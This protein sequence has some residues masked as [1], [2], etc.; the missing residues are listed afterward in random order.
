MCEF[1]FVNTGAN[2]FSPA[3]YMRV[4]LPVHVCVGVYVDA[5]IGY[6]PL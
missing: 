4:P 5:C 1:Q 6:G 3:V 2:R